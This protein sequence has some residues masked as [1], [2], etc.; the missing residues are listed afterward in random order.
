MNLNN[1]KREKIKM[2][3]YDE[4]PGMLAWL[5]CQDKGVTKRI[6]A[7]LRAADNMFLYLT[8]DS[9]EGVTAKETWA[10]AVMGIEEDLKG[11]TEI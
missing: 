4:M 1:P 9:E 3:V 6:A 8:A 5:D 10:S 2:R 7:A 11:V